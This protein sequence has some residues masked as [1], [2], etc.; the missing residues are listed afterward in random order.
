MQGDLEILLEVVHFYDELRHTQETKVRDDFSLMLLESERN[1]AR[2]QL[3]LVQRA[4]EFEWGCLNS[5]LLALK[6]ELDSTYQELASSQDRSLELAQ[7][8]AVSLEKG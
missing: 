6:G 1:Y 3:S 5:N 8:L 7:E 4:F 2:T